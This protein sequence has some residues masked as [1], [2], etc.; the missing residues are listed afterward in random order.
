MDCVFVFFLVII[1]TSRTA[2]N[3]ASV[4]LERQHYRRPCAAFKLVE[5]FNDLVVPPVVANPNAVY[6][7]H[8]TARWCG[9]DVERLVIL[10]AYIHTCKCRF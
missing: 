5:R 2:W 7:Y 6:L 3:G 8:Q 4:L 1:V 10:H 9:G